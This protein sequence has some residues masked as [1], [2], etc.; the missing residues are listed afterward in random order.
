[1]L[2]RIIRDS[3]VYSLSGLLTSG[4]SLLLVP[5]Y[6]RVFSPGDYGV[7][8]MLAIVTTLV[9]LT[10]ALEVRQAIG[11]FALDTTDQGERKAYSST[12]LF[13]TVAVYVV[14]ALVSIAASPW[15]GSLLLGS[16]GYAPLIAVNSLYIL[17]FGIYSLLLVQLVYLS[18][19]TR[20]TIVNLVYSGV[21]IGS[22]VLL[23]LVLKTGVI[24]V[25]YGLLAGGIA[26]CLLSFLYSRDAFA[27]VFDPTRL[28][29]MLIFSIPLVPSSVGV[30]V[31]L[32]VDR[33]A[34]N[35]LMTLADVG[36][37]GIGYR[38]ASIVGLL[39]SATQLAVTPYIYAHYR[40]ES[41]Q[42]ELARTFRLFMAFGLFTLLCLGLFADEILLVFTTPRYYGAA[43]LIP[44]LVGSVLV[45][46]LYIFAP[47]AWIVKRTKV[48]TVI[49]LSVAVLNLALNLLL[50]PLLGLIGAGLATL[51][52]ATVG[53]VVQFLISQRFYPLR[54][55]WPRIL[56]SV[57]LVA[58]LLFMVNAI[59]L[60]ISPLGFVAK[61][62]A[63]ITGTAVIA[64]LL[65][66]RG[67]ISAG[68]GEIRG[69]L[70]LPGLTGN[71]RS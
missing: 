5:L 16:T 1:M 28:R 11:R 44:F 56:A 39:I 26:G 9:N 61:G 64:L 42:R 54:Y 55:P 3:S 6:T 65:T 63:A 36:L 59:S 37:Y 50:I 19:P 20:Y 22:T 58:V 14:F 21:S 48:I 34:I 46:G 24:G 4:I 40:E 69:F 29:E 52:S 17:V 38:F 8:D 33:M 68:I 62:V 12:A 45:S 30:F 25:F 57:V 70:S 41:T 31:S 60:P 71:G 7:I 53:F 18:R 32:Y 66:S 13:F 49:N 47:G 51:A 35:T 15:I 27:L 10:I 43:D 67:E 2:K 23:V